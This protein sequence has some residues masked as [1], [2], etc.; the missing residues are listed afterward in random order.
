MTGVQ[1]CALPIFDGIKSV[2]KE[3]FSGSFDSIFGYKSKEIDEVTES[4]K[5]LSAEI[6]NL[7]KIP[8]ATTG[9]FNRSTK[10]QKISKASVKEVDNW[11]EEYKKLAD[12]VDS[13]DPSDFEKIGPALKRMRELGMSIKE[14]LE[15]PNIQKS[16]GFSEYQS[17]LKESARYFEKSVD[18]FNA[19][20]QEKLRDLRQQRKAL[21]DELITT[22]ESA[23][24]LSGQI[25][26]NKKQVNKKSTTSLGKLDQT[27]DVS[28]KPKVDVGVWS[29]TINQKLKSIQDKLEPVVL[30]ATFSNK[31]K[32]LEKE[33]DGNIAAINHTVKAEF[34]IEDNFGNENDPN[35]FFGKLR[36]LDTDLQE[37]KEKLSSKTQFKV[38]FAFESADGSVVTNVK[39]YVQNQFKNI[40]V[41]LHVKNGKSFMASITNMING[42][43]GNFE[44]SLTDIPVSFKIK[45]EEE[46]LQSVYALKETIGSNMNDIGVNFVTNGIVNIGDAA[47][48]AT[49]EVEELSA[50]VEKIDRKS[51][52]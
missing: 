29:N 3:K 30:K 12:E 4:I 36:K 37:A 9:T 33:L 40:P 47:D 32:N 2:G 31:S 39:S 28:V 41:T 50:S 20:I 22:Q 1:T 19:N 21:E 10:E 14:A 8:G 26:T 34:N 16:K 24:K 49:K 23:A 48:V 6:D 25:S 18:D 5:K 46:L 7:K 45:N 35:S 15:L 11:V 27:V 52:V 17:F 38:R 42:V 43:K 13:I 44:K 51:V